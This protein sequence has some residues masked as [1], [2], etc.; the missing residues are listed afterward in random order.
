[1]LI[2]PG[3]TNVGFGPMGME[4]HTEEAEKKSRTGRTGGMVHR[5]CYFCVLLVGLW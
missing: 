3:D 4:K 5:R 1:M 2:A